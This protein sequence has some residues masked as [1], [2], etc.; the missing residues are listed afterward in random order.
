[1]VK[2]QRLHFLAVCSLLVG[3]FVLAGC[4]SEHRFVKDA[5][6]SRGVIKS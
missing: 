4:A 3:I 6:L 1:M 5:Q 2:V